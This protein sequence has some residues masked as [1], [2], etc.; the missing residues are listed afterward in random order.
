M[1]LQY[2]IVLFL[3]VSGSI[4]AMEI[5]E[6]KDEYVMC[7]SSAMTLINKEHPQEYWETV[8]SQNWNNNESEREKFK[9]RFSKPRYITYSDNDIVGNQFVADI[10]PHMIRS[11]Q[12]RIS[13][14]DCEM[15][16]C[17]L[18]QKD[19]EI[20]MKYQKCLM[21]L[22]DLP[23]H[24][25]NIIG[26]FTKRS[27]KDT[28]RCVNKALNQKIISQDE[29]YEQLYQAVG[30][31][32][33][34][35]FED[36]TEL[37]RLLC[38][39]TF[40]PCGYG[41]LLEAIKDN[42]SNI[43]LIKHCMLLAKRDVDRYKLLLCDIKVT[44]N[45]Y[46]YS[47]IDVAMKQK[48]N[49]DVLKTL[50]EAEEKSEAPLMLQAMEQNN[51]SMMR[52]LVN[53]GVDI[54]TIYKGFP[55]LQH[56]VRKGKTEIVEELVTYS[57]LDINQ[58]NERD[59]TALFFAYINFNEKHQETSDFMKNLYFQD[60]ACMMRVLMKAGANPELDR[61]S[62]DSAYGKII[63]TNIQKCLTLECDKEQ[64]MLQVIKQDNI[65]MMRVLVKNV[66]DI[67]TIYAVLLHAVKEINIE[68]V[69]ELIAYPGLD[70]NKR[71]DMQRLWGPKFNS[72]LYYAVN[73]ISL[74]KDQARMS[75]VNEIIQIL[76]NAGADPKPIAEAF[77]GSFFGSMVS[78]FIQVKS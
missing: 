11:N 38:Y 49:I 70:L 36:A 46:L 43:P 16:A 51:I 60:V 14:K 28:L 71:N 1:I 61:Y 23:E 66:V 21:R 19:A 29:L 4:Q 52:M 69:K 18:W 68:A 45:E 27:G 58:K 44:F 10:L 30:S 59:M 55:L 56:A 15:L 47:C 75:E 64:L 34:S 12:K 74:C 20:R 63:C 42:N 53:Y 25:L 50:I 72:A 65:S 37:E 17:L 5:M 54:N 24:E 13:S 9:D 26:A 33:R 2:F 39:N 3:C 32:F 73:N 62:K 7:M 77:E 48:N 8:V 6:D 31:V 76:L 40:K 67:N 22:G 41:E 78:S 35:G 57:G